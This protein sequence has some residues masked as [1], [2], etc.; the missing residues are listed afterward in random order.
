MSYE[1]RKHDVSFDESLAML[2][3]DPRPPAQRA[4]APFSSNSTKT[5]N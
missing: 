3:R 1:F 5:L 2:M 4:S